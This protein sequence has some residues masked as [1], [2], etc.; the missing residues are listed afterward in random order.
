MGEK[1]ACQE[2]NRTL[3]IEQHG[4]IRTKCP[5]CGEIQTLMAASHLPEGRRAPGK[6]QGDAQN[7]KA[8]PLGPG[9]T[10]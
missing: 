2:C 3:A 8:A 1:I 6:E 4:E 10:R 9:D 5:R 7:G